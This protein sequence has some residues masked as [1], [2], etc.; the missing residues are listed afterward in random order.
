MTAIK[1]FC[2][3]ELSFDLIAD[4]ARGFNRE[5]LRFMPDEYIHNLEERIAMSHA[6]SDQ[7]AG[8]CQPAS[9]Q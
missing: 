5:R 3:L 2:S 9:T 6:V 4:E 7:S 8:G 1:I